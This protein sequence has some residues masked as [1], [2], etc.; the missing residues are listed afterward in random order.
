MRSLGAPRAQNA[1][2]ASLSPRSAIASPADIM[3]AQH[4]VM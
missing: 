4:E 3:G 1:S 2:Q